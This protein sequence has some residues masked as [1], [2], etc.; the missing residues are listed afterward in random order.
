METV[1]LAAF[2]AFSGPFHVAAQVVVE[3]PP[4][5]PARTGVALLNSQNDLTPSVSSGEFLVLGNDADAT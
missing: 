5:L 1:L 3:R 2:L 4:L